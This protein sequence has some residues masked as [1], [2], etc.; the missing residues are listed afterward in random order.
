MDTASLVARLEHPTSSGFN[1]V[2]S[3]AWSP[4]GDMLA[5]GDSDGVV[6]L[7][8]TATWSLLAEMA[9]LRARR[10]IQKLRFS[11]EGDRLVSL[12]DNHAESWDV[13]SR[14]IAWE[15]KER[16]NPDLI[17]AAGRRII[18]SNFRLLDARSGKWVREKRD[19]IGETPIG[20][21]LD[22]TLIATIGPDDST[23]TI[24]ARDLA[25]MDVVETL[26]VHPRGPDPSSF[27]WYSFKQAQNGAV[28]GYNE[29]GLDYI[30][31]IS[32]RPW[33]VA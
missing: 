29:D 1:Y 26:E 31:N 14:S 11:P 25:S 32:D 27:I 28:I 20:I 18:C 2:L 8:D 13:A 15:T 30:M 22:G 24:I 9:E 16:V 17:D 12:R 21:S 33:C 10:H 4:R 5:T 7:W 23:R 3:V 19:T 6:R